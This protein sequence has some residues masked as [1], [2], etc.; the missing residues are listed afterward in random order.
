MRNTPSSE[1]RPDPPD[2]EVAFWRGFI[3]W[4]ARQNEEP[5]PERAWAALNDAEERACVR[6]EH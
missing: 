2:E 1:A 3:E 5:V 6:T 4:W